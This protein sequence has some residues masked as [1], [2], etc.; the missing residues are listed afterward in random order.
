MRYDLGTF[1]VLGIT[2]IK[3]LLTQVDEGLL[4]EVMDMSEQTK[5]FLADGFST[6]FYGAIV[7]LCCAVIT[8]TSALISFANIVQSI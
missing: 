2:N 7:V 4:K 8:F 3:K 1:C 6:L 5:N